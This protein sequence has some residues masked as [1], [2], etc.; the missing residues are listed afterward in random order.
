MRTL[1]SI[2]FLSLCLRLS[3]PETNCITI[4]QAEPIDPILSLFKAVS[5]V[6][7]SNRPKIVNEKEQAYGIVQIRQGKLFDYNRA[8][9]SS[10]TLEDCFNV[11]VSKKIFY[12]FAGTFDYRD[13][14]GI[15]KAWNGAGK[16]NEIYWQK[17]KNKLKT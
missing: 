14:E 2:F 11:E 10:Y 12:F 16:S 9:R 6:E 13:Y 4:F 1:L 5:F 17:I 3:A 7:S 8:T 15:A